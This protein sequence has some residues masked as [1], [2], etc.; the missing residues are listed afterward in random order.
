MFF[1]SLISSTMLIGLLC[2]AVAVALAVGLARPLVQLGYVLDKTPAP[3]GAHVVFDREARVAVRRGDGAGTVDV[4]VH[5]WAPLRIE[6]ASQVYP[7]VLYAPGWGGTRND[8]TALAATLASH[9][10]VVAAID[11]VIHDPA[12]LDTSTRD[13]HVRETVMQIGD[14]AQ[15]AR[16]VGTFNAR[17]ALEARKSSAVLD[18]LL[19]TGTLDVAGVDVDPRR[20]G[21]L[22]AS[23]GGAAAVEAALA[24]RRFRAVINLDGWL[25]G[26]ALTAVLDVPFANF[27]STRGVPDPAILSAA[28]ANAVQRFLAARNGETNDFIQRQIAARSDALDISIA[29]ANHGDYT[30]EVYD[31]QRWQQWRPWRRQMIAPGRMHEVMDAYV[32]AFF[33]AH[34][35]GRAAPWITQSPSRYREV[36]IRLGRGR[37]PE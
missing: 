17:L 32:A 31:P 34:L 12:E 22:G 16:S 18:A 9:G 15:R 14:E 33:G 13:R 30:D 29:G 35:G 7:L 8:N 36:S 19:A 24:D 23:F 2:A 10:F 1:R 21:M 26:R 25:R 20:V 5:F 27:N 28:N 37:A 11:D 4:A 3:R 6:G